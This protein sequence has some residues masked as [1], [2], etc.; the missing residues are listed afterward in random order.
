MKEASFSL[1]RYNF[2]L[3]KLNLSMLKDRQVHFNLKIIPEGQFSK[4]EQIFVLRFRFF[5]FL[6]GDEENPCVEITCE[7]MYAFKDVDSIDNIPPY[8]YANSIAIL[9]P[10]VRAFIST[11]TLQAN[12]MPIVLPTMNLSDLSTTL[13]E[14]TEV[15]E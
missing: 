4:T 1:K 14:R 5:A 15:V 13:K 12:Y 7:G 3:V 8:F 10:Y 11:V 6:D 2:P 9:F